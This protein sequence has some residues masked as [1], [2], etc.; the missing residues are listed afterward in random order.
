MTGSS[1]ADH[2]SATRFQWQG[3]YH[4]QMAAAWAR[5]GYLVLDGFVSLDDCQAMR[6]RADQLIA[7][8][9]VDAHRVVFSAKGQSHAASDYFMNSAGNISCFLEEDAMDET[10]QLTKDKSKAI[11]KIGHALHDLDP[12]FAEVS[13]ASQFKTLAHGI[14]MT[15]PLLLQSMVICKQPYIGGEV[16]THQDSTFLYTA[17]ETCTGF[18][19]A[20]EEATVENGCMWAAPGGHHSD[21]RQRFVREGEGRDMQMTMQT[22]SDAPLPECTTPLP[23]KPG[24]LVLLHGRLPHLS[25]PNRSAQS[26][27]AYAVHYID[28]TADYAAE[29]WL[30]RPHDMPLQGF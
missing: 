25:A 7:D 30:Q 15:Q 9:D 5:D 28:G 21:L 20:L 2:P 19:L 1:S 26:R 10:G 12:V 4:P 23:A 27:Y 14:G 22:L 6:A 3:D 8:F 24:T 18:W 16:N 17:P 29:N 13:R 11:N